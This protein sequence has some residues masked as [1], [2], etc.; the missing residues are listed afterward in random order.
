M[1]RSSRVPEDGQLL[2]ALVTALA[3]TPDLDPVSADGLFGVD[4]EVVPFSCING[5]H[6]K[7]F[8]N[9][10]RQRAK[11]INKVR[12]HTRERDDRVDDHR[13]HGFSV[14]SD[15]DKRMSLDGDLSRTYG[16]QRVDHSE[17]VSSTRRDSESL[18][19]GVGAESRVAV[20]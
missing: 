4:D 13:L 6:T 11:K 2:D 17:P 20:L 5:S 3:E 18:Q 19:R 12:R 9:G 7:G 15:Q 16:R 10:V 8:K 1:V 14:G